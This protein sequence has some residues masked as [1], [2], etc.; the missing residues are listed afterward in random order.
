M[1][2]VHVLYTQTSDAVWF[3]R[4]PHTECSSFTQIFSLNKAEFTAF[5]CN[6]V[7]SSKK[8]F[9][10]ASSLTEKRELPDM[11]LPWPSQITH[12]S[13]LGT[14]LSMG[15]MHNRLFEQLLV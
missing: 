9:R 12:S 5:S 10:G 7:L 1:L 6:L 8:N 13:A 3:L 11:C 2:C 15:I 4:K 14:G